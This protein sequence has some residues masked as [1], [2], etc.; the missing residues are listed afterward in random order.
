MVDPSR[1]DRKHTGLCSGDDHF[2]MA[3]DRVDAE[4]GFNDAAQY[5]R[6]PK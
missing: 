6:C 3:G 4:P 5:C 2:G 1:R